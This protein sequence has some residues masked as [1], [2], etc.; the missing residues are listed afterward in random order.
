MKL[1]F[2]CRADVGRGRIGGHTRLAA[3][4]IDGVDNVP[5]VQQAGDGRFERDLRHH[6]LRRGYLNKITEDRVKARAA[7]ATQP[8]AKRLTSLLGRE[9]D[10]DRFKVVIINSSS[11][12]QR[13]V[14]LFV[15][16]SNLVVLWSSHH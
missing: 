5:W 4:S 11:S 10:G 16:P 6:E 13:A 12:P 7:G 1:E 14:R 15:R 2:G 8:N 9:L 3:N